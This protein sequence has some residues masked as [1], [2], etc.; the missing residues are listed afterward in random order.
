MYADVVG[1]DA[2]NDER[3]T[4]EWKHSVCAQRDP[5][6]APEAPLSERRSAERAPHASA[7][8]RST[9]TPR[10]AHEVEFAS[11]ARAQLEPSEG[12]RPTRPNASAHE[13]KRSAFPGAAGD[14]GCATLEQGAAGSDSNARRPRAQG[15]AQVAFKTQVER[16]LRCRIQDPRRTDEELRLAA[17]GL[18][19]GASS[20][21]SIN[22][23]LG[24]GVVIDTSAGPSRAT[25][26]MTAAAEAMVSQ[27]SAWRTRSLETPRATMRITAVQFES[28][29]RSTSIRTLPAVCPPEAGPRAR[30]TCSRNTSRAGQ[31]V[32]AFHAESIAAALGCA[33]ASVGAAATRSAA[34]QRATERRAST[35]VVRL[36]RRRSVRSPDPGEAPRVV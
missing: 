33:D 17:E 12:L 2:C 24:G 6:C 16:R 31:S 30:P 9:R 26:V 29:S 36:K 10:P 35:A 7:L 18:R 11:Q 34:K 23:R 32:G 3:G 1:A 22:G 8:S 20:L 5:E 21:D 13:G 15:Q 19:R 28:A 25:A 27:L 4:R 14:G